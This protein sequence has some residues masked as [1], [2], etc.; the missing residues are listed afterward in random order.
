MRVAFKIFL[1]PSL[2][3]HASILGSTPLACTRAL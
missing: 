2:L 1:V 3:G